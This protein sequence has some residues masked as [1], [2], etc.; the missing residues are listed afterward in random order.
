MHSITQ[1]KRSH[2]PLNVVDTSTVFK[3]MTNKDLNPNY[4]FIQELRTFKRCDPEYDK[5]KEHLQC[6]TP[7][8]SFSEYV[9]GDNVTSSSKYV[10]MDFDP[11]DEGFDREKEIKCLNNNP[12]V[13]A[14]WTSAGGIGIGCLLKADWTDQN[15][16]TFKSA[17]TS[18]VNTLKTYGSTMSYLDMSCS[19]ISRL[20]FISYSK[21]QIKEDAITIEKPVK[22][23]EGDVKSF[24][25]IP[26]IKDF[27]SP[28][29]YVESHSKLFY[30][31][32][33]ED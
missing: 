12:H 30:N 17:F 29:S 20:N 16:I 33:I 4:K 10:Y 6:F 15:P 26:C 24:I 3:M 8:A 21:V 5:I 27:A 14:H 11:K 31:T 22:E 7:N 13:Y 28:S 1:N 23:M 2:I 25:Y 19:N 18:A 9:D 32:Q